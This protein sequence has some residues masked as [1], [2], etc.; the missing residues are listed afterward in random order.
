[1]ADLEA[2]ESRVRSFQRPQIGCKNT[3]ALPLTFELGLP[4]L[5][6]YLKV[7][8]RHACA[9]GAQQQARQ[10]AGTVERSG[11]DLMQGQRR[12]TTRGGG[13]GYG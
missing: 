3:L 8:I 1:M 9:P 4:G 12:E 10:P 2:A 6:H 5:Q 13:R 11:K 7:A